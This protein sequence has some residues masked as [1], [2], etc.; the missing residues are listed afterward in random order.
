MRIARIPVYV[1]SPPTPAV[2]WLGPVERLA[3]AAANRCAVGTSMLKH[4]GELP[5]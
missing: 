2:G 5:A 4:R 3:G 1:W